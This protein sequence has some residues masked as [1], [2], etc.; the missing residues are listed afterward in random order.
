MEERGLK[1]SDWNDPLDSREGGG[2]SSSESEQ[3]F[4]TNLSSTSTSKVS[5]SNNAQTAAIMDD[6]MRKKILNA[7]KRIKKIENMLEKHENEMA[8]IDAAMLQVTKEFY[9]Y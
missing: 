5:I 8:S 4:A 2:C 3:K 7:P 6:E 9:L 1:D